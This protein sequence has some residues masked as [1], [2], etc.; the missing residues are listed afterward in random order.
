MGT[1]A[2]RPGTE[3]H[4]SFKDNIP[5][6]YALSMS[7][8]KTPHNSISKIDACRNASLLLCML[9]MRT[10]DHEREM[11]NGYFIVLLCPSTYLYSRKLSSLP[12]FL[13]MAFDTG[14]L[15]ATNS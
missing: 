2:N 3:G 8:K 1:R 13:M 6:F 4:C 15:A 7:A 12:V 9:S 5:L 10:Q 14:G 11:D